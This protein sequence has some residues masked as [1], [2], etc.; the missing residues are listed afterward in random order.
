MYRQGATGALLD[1]Y[2]QAIAALIAVIAPISDR[3]LPL[4][5]DPITSDEHCRSLQSI[6]AHVVHSGYGY[7]T[8]IHNRKGNRSERPA[9]ILHN[10]M[11]A[12][13]ED[14][15]A[16]FRYTEQVFS[17]VREDE[18]EQYEE[19][20]KIRTGW[21]QLY[22]IEQLTEHAIVHILRHTRQIKRCYPD[23]QV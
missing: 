5:I 21:G 15:V 12:Y 14:L 16:M 9:L 3:L 2:E 13:R 17:E 8:S 1:V 11:Q 6:L 18:L 19:T 22:D 4:V 10:N 23:P 7:A 20:L